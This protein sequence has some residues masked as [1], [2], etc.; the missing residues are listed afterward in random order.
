M[1]GLAAALLCCACSAPPTIWIEPATGIEFVLLPA[2]EFEDF[3]LARLAERY[4]QGA[5]PRPTWETG[6]L[7]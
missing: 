1:P 2:G 4:S 6:D 5:D 3:L 7:A